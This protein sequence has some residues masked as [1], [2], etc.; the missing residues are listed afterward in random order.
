[1]FIECLTVEKR[2]KVILMDCDP[3][4][5]YPSEGGTCSPEADCIPECDPSCWP[6]EYDT[7]S[8]ETNTC[9]PDYGVDCTPNCDP[10]DDY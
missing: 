9:G 10:S 7:C 6:A 2:E 4:D 1:M 5:C 8:P 3:D